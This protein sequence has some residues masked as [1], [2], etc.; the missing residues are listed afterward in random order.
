MKYKLHHKTDNALL[1]RLSE[2]VHQS[3]CVEAELVAHIGEVEARRL[4]AREAASSM[5][6]YCRQVLGL[7]EHE[8]YLRIGV[9][10]AA[11]KHP[12]LLDMLGDGRLFLSGIARLA[13]LLTEANRDTVLTRAAGMSKREIEEL[14]AELSPKPDARAV[15]RKLPEKREKA[16]PNPSR[17]LVPERVEI[18]VRPNPAPP[19]PAPSK[20]AVV[21]PLSPAKYKVQ[22][23]AS[24]ELRDKLERLRALMRSSIPDGDLA[25]IIEEAVTEKLERLESKRFGKTKAP[26]KSLKEAK[27]SLSSR[28]IPA[29]IR[30]AVYERDQGQCTFVGDNG[31]RCSERSRLEFHHLNPYGRGGGHKVENIKLLCRVHNGY[32]AERD[33]GKEVME[34]YRRSASRVNE[35]AAF[36]THAN[37]Q[38]NC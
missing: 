27:T 30:R 2:L 22:F 13:P 12:V 8:A 7:S 23:T 26:R 10:R 34:R 5:F 32:F 16:K 14:V 17:Q 37:C 18:P 1:R 6:I 11:R 21:E 35:P 24:A 33:Y 31:R 15:M 20:P 19:D 25:A 9:A 36:Y 4:Y 38:S 3:R 29:P 28:Y